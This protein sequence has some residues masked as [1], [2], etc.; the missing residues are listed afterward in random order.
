MVTLDK[1]KKDLIVTKKDLDEAITDDVR[2]LMERTH[3]AGVSIPSKYAFQCSCCKGIGLPY[4]FYALIKEKVGPGP[5]EKTDI[6]SIK[7]AKGVVLLS[8]LG[9]EPEYS[10]I[11][12]IT[13]DGPTCDHCYET[14]YN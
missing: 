14:V 1:L 6:R 7:S 9:F 5:I 2:H 11:L 13:K 3:N 12:H 8:K 10:S 4:S